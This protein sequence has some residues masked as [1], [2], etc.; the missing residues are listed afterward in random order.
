MIE[1]DTLSFFVLRVIS[2]KEIV[3]E[4]LCFGWKQMTPLVRAGS[5]ITLYRWIFCRMRNFQVQISM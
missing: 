2:I 4:L 5:S 1:V 3:E